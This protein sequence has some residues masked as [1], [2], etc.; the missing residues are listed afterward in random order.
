MRKFLVLLL[1]LV[2]LASGCTGSPRPTGTIEVNLTPDIDGLEDFSNLVIG[3]ERID[4]IKSSGKK[5]GLLSGIDKFDLKNIQNRPVV[6]GEVPAEGYRGFE[7]VFNAA[8]GLS[9]DNRMVIF[10]SQNVTVTQDFSVESGSASSFKVTLS[11]E[12]AAENDYE[13]IATGVEMDQ[14]NF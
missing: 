8:Y 13:L 3:V 9:K 11:V 4:L 7:I 14:R 12:K 1:F 10:R 5:A 6:A 2:L